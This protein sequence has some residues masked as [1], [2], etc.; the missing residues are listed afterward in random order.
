MLA[1]LAQALGAALA[2]S[3]IRVFIM[4]KT[5]ISRYQSHG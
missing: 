3:G 4:R 5:N 2:F 1:F